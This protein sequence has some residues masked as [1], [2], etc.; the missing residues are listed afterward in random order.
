MAFL[1]A[2]SQEYLDEAAEAV[3]TNSGERKAKQ[4]FV[5]SSDPNWEMAWPLILV[6][7]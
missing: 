7:V 6:L 5:L 2:R 3:S 1:K 4:I